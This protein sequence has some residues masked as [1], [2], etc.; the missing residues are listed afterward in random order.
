MG[1]F[2]RVGG[3]GGGN[4]TGVGGFF[5]E[6]DGQ[7]Y[8]QGGGLAGYGDGWAGK[9]LRDKGSLARIVNKGSGKNFGVVPVLK[10]W[11]RER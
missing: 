4:Q 1:C 2:C 6:L 11:R 10:S 5:F 7:E 8:G 9:N 3:W